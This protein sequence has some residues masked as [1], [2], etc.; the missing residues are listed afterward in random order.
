MSK[1]PLEPPLTISTGSPCL[2]NRSRV[3]MSRRIHLSEALWREAQPITCAQWP[4]YPCS[5]RRFSDRSLATS[6]PRCSAGSPG[7]TPVRRPPTSTSTRTFST[8]PERPIAAASSRM[9]SA[10]STTASVSGF[11]SS[12]FRSRPIFSAPTT[13]VVMRR[14]RMPAAAITSASPTL[15]TQTPTAP[16]A[17]CR[18]AISGHLWVLAWGRIFLPTAFTCA[19]I[20]CRLRSKRSRSRSSAGVGSSALVMAGRIARSPPSRGARAPPSSGS[21]DRTARCG[22]RDVGESGWP[23]MRRPRGRHRSGRPAGARPGDARGSARR[24]RPSRAAPRECECRHRRSRRASDPPP[25]RRR[26]PPPAGRCDACPAARRPPPRAQS[27]RPGTGGRGGRGSRPRSAPPRPRRRPP[28][29]PGRRRR[30][31]PG[32]SGDERPPPA[33]ARAA[34]AEGAAPA[35]EAAARRAPARSAAEPSEAATTEE[36]AAAP[37]AG[38]ARPAVPPRAHRVSLSGEDDAQDHEKGEANGD[39]GG[40]G[41]VAARGAARVRPVLALDGG[42]DG[43][44][45]RPDAV[46]HLPLAEAW[47]HLLAQDGGRDG[48]G[49]SALQ[50]IADLD[51]HLPVVEEDQEDD[52]VVEALLAD[53]PCLG[54]PDRIVL[55]AL[56]LEG[57][58][59]RDHHL[60]AAALLTLGEACLQAIAIG[61]RQRA[62]EIVDPPGGRG[63]DGQGAHHGRQQDGEEGE[64]D[65]QSDRAHRGLRRGR[66]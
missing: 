17:I 49:E 39:Q 37:T 32:P 6:L 25:P 19:A 34:A 45:T 57:A 51:P 22:R 59:D 13:S 48:V 62:R 63:R 50:P 53:A 31:S 18:R 11:L 66:G 10:L 64:R 41:V 54:E 30:G 23:A 21:R 40:N 26:A 58:E 5:P 61:R 29:R 9:F 60:V 16:A 27:D 65:R 28:P 7:S 46:G 2:S 8:L 55:E 47:G 35:A 42:D 4:A 14:F 56:P 24:G 52:A 1:V 38:A 43:I 12:T 20:F 3:F 36:R 33:P 15:A 44:Q